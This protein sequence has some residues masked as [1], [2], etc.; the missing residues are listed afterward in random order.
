MEFCQC[1]DPQVENHRLTQWTLGLAG[2]RKFKKVQTMTNIA[3]SA[4]RLTIQ[5]HV[6]LFL[7]K[8]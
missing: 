6:C 4:R 1:L 2:F 3:F 8:L 5:E 7:W